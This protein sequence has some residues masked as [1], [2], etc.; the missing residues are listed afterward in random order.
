MYNILLSISFVQTTQ[1]LYM[2]SICGGISN[3]L[4]EQDGLPR[5][6]RRVLSDGDNIDIRPFSH[7]ATRCIFLGLPHRKSTFSRLDILI[8]YK[9]SCISMFSRKRFENRISAGLTTTNN[10]FL[11]FLLNVPSDFFIL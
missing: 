7:L 3:Y 2:S 11:L 10:F 6:V 8:C 4:E 5:R 1:S 9:L